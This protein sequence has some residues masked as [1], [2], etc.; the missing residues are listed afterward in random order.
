MLR[1]AGDI[2]LRLTDTTSR[3]CEGAAVLLL[4]GFAG[5]MLAEVV[6]RGFIGGSL[7]YSW[8]ISTYAMAAMFF[9]AAGR[10]LRTGRHV[11]VSLLLEASGPRLRAGVEAAAAVVALVL[12]VGIFLSLVDMTRASFARDLRA[13]TFTATPLAWPQMALAVGAGQLVLDL[14]ARLVRLMRGEPLQEQSADEPPDD[15]PEESPSATTARM[16]DDG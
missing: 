8:E 16:R 3:L 6:K 5:L 10:T 13:P 9:L 12:A 15:A 1:R 11:R 7:A 14:L 4:F 2:F